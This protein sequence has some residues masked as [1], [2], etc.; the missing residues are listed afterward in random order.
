MRGLARKGVLVTDEEDEEL[1]ELPARDEVLATSGWN[2]YGA[3]HYLMT[4]WSGVD[5]RCRPTKGSSR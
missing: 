5:L 4:K 2:L 3:L 1:A